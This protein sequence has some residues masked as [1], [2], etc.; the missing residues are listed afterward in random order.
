MENIENIVEEQ[1]VKKKR[2][3]KPKNPENKIYFSDKQ[4]Q[5]V[6]DYIENRD[7]AMLRNQ[8]YVQIL[9]PAFEKMIESIIRTYRLYV[10]DEEFNDTVN[11]ALNNLAEQIDKFKVNSGKKAYSYYGT[12][13][14]HYVLKR[15]LDYINNIEKKPSYESFEE[16][17]IQAR[18]MIDTYERDKRIAQQ[19]LKHLTTRI[20][21]MVENPQSEGLKKNEL[22]LG[23]G[24]INLFENWESI[25][26]TSI[27][28]STY[29]GDVRYVSPS[30]KLNKSAVLLYLREQTG[31]DSK[32][33]RS[34]LKKYRKEF[35]M[36]KDYVFE[37][38]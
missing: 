31:L 11:D 4:E 9:K 20:K 32:S 34:N 26:P 8:L 27:E 5:A 15:K 7:N 37:N 3:R 10:P 14:K 35:L 29:D 6:I 2:G 24:L 22:K 21:K 16:G 23:M 13:V 38:Y 12:I 17:D 1:P 28:K 33:I 18:A 36:I 30:K 25:V 19:Q